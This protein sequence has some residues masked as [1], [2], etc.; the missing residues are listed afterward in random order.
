MA[1]LK[2]WAPRAYKDLELRMPAVLPRIAAGKCQATQLD[3]LDAAIAVDA[4]VTYVD[5]PYNQHSYIA[6]YHIWESLVLWDKPDTYG[7]ACKRLDVKE[8]RSVFNS[9]SKFKSAFDRLIKAI[10]SPVIVVSF[11]NE[12]YIDQPTMEHML[13]SLWDG[14][15]R[16]LTLEQDYKR[17]VGAQ[18]GIHNPKGERVGKVSHLRNKEFIYV[19]SRGD[20]LL[21]SPD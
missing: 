1:Y 5:P 3:A 17:Y 10:R 18:I 21:V 19:V 11:S 2:S 14:D 16:V 20:R 9:K 12:G 7:V 6:N 15:A 4:D 8:R 13:S